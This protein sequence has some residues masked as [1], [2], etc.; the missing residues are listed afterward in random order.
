MITVARDSLPGLVRN[1]NSNT[2]NKFD[3][4]ISEKRAIRAGNGFN[5]FQVKI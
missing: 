1:L 5:L 4:K 2:I 3:R